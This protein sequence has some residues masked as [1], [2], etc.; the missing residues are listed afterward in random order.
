M[1][2]KDGYEFQGKYENG[3]KITGVMKWRKDKI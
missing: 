2:V 3:K 1:N